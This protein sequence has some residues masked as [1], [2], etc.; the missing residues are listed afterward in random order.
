MERTLEGLK[1]C[2]K[3]DQKSLINSP[4]MVSIERSR[5]IDLLVDVVK[6]SDLRIRLQLFI[7][8]NEFQ[9]H[10]KK[11][12]PEVHTLLRLYLTVAVHNSCILVIAIPSLTFIAWM[13]TP[14]YNHACAVIYFT[15]HPHFII[16][17]A[18]NDAMIQCVHITIL[19]LQINIYM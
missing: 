1:W 9:Q 8:C 7:H 19:V 18:W 5:S 10:C 15:A 11:M 13:H 17:M 4:L 6:Q 16:F 14:L 3:W 2:W 12:L